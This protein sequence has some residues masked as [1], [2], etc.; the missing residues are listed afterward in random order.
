MYTSIIVLM[1]LALHWATAQPLGATGNGKSDLRS[2]GTQQM[3]C[4]DAERAAQIDKFSNLALR[5]YQLEADLNPEVRPTKIINQNKTTKQQQSKIE[6]AAQKESGSKIHQCDQVR[7]RGGP[8]FFEREAEQAHWAI[9]G[10]KI[11]W[12]KKWGELFKFFS[13]SC[14]DSKQISNRDGDP[15][16]G[17][18]DVR[19]ASGETVSGVEGRRSCHFADDPKNALRCRTRW[20]SK[21]SAQWN[22]SVGWVEVLTTGGVLVMLEV[23]SRSVGGIS[24]GVARAMVIRGVVLLMAICGMATPWYALAECMAATVIVMMEGQG[25]LVSTEE[26][27]M[28]F[29]HGIVLPVMMGGGLVLMALLTGGMVL[30][31][32]D[33]AKTWMS[34]FAGVYGRGVLRGWAIYVG[35][36]FA[37]QLVRCRS[38]VGALCAVVGTQ[39]E[40]AVAAGMELQATAA[41]AMLTGVLRGLANVAWRDPIAALVC[42]G[43]VAGGVLAGPWM[44]CGIATLAAN[45][46]WG[47]GALGTVVRMAGDMVMTGPDSGVL[48]ALASMKPP[49]GVQQK[50]GD[51]SRQEVTAERDTPALAGR[52][53]GRGATQRNRSG[54]TASGNRDV[55]SVD[56]GDAETGGTVATHAGEAGRT[57]EADGGNGDMEPGGSGGSGGND[58]TGG[59]DAAVGIAD[60]GG[61]EEVQWEDADVPPGVERRAEAREESEAMRGAYARLYA[62]ETIDDMQHRAGIT[63]T[64][65]WID[66]PAMKAWIASRV[67]LKLVADGPRAFAV[68]TGLVLEAAAKT[69]IRIVE[70]GKGNSMLGMCGAPEVRFTRVDNREQ[71]RRLRTL[72]ALGRGNLE[73]AR[74]TWSETVVEGIDADAEIRRLFPSG[75]GRRVEAMRELT[76]GGMSRVRRRLAGESEAEWDRVVLETIDGAEDNAPG[77]SGLRIGHLKQMLRG[78]GGALMKRAFGKMVDELLKGADGKHVRDVVVKLL[79]KGGG[80]ARPI[81]MGEVLPAVAK[82]LAAKVLRQDMQDCLLGM[83]Q[84]AEV[85]NGCQAAAREVDWMIGEGYGLLKL[86]MVNAFNAVE[87]DAIIEEVGKVSPDAAPFVAH[88]L[89]DGTYIT[90]CGRAVMMSRGV[91]QGDPLSMPIFAL[92]VARR[93]QAEMVDQQGARPLNGSGAD[94]R[95]GVRANGGTIVYG[96]YADDVVILARGLTDLRRGADAAKS[97]MERIGLE[98]NAAKS[99]IIPPRGS[100]T[101]EVAEM[102]GEWGAADM[103]KATMYLG[104]PVGEME[105]ARKLLE[106]KIGEVKSE[107]EG[108]A[109]IRSPLGQLMLM[110]ACHPLSRLQ[111]VLEGCA[112]GVVDEEAMER[113]NGMEEDAMRALLNFGQGATTVGWGRDLTEDGLRQMALPL[114]AGGLGISRAMDAGRLTEDGW[115]RYSDEERDE[116]LTERVKLMAQRGETDRVMAKRWR[117]QGRGLEWLDRTTL[118]RAVESALPGV[119]QTGTKKGTAEVQAGMLARMVGLCQIPRELRDEKCGAV[120]RPVSPEL[121]VDGTDHT[122]QCRVLAVNQRHEAAKRALK[123]LLMTAFEEKDIIFEARPSA[124]GAP[125]LRA[126]GPRGEGQKVPGDVVLMRQGEAPVYMDVSICYSTSRAYAESDRDEATRVW[127]DKVA[128]WNAEAQREP[129]RGAFIP[130]VMTTNGHLHPRS[131]NALIQLFPPGA[132]GDVIDGLRTMMLDVMLTTSELAALVVQKANQAIGRPADWAGDDVNGIME[133]AQPAQPQHGGVRRY[134]RQPAGRGRGSGRGQGRGGAGGR[135]SSRPAVAEVTAARP[136]A[137]AAGARAVARPAAAAVGARAVARPAAAAMEAVAGAAPLVGPAVRRPGQEEVGAAGM[138]RSKDVAALAAT[139]AEYSARR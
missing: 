42:A 91:V 7:N 85:Q 19:K 45:S 82:R 49:P 11:F 3:D 50:W 57:R 122:L 90:E 47:L 44:V 36:D 38:P 23:V 88:L 27:W 55:R 102:M 136:A 94:F 25:D 114:K 127:D 5:G 32:S 104:I 113:I 26:W 8:D 73:L 22:V 39:L 15:L 14:S 69:H 129:V 20:L 30:L 64:R 76:D 68:V 37:I 13:G 112:P 89:Q 35:G 117:E 120:H 116:R 75:N 81:G 93:L 4:R 83:G 100:R 137:A 108:W 53:S 61:S 139:M 6:F 62:P 118:R 77:R 106:Q 12:P 97:A 48:S 84:W 41:A 40:T 124:S 95:A 133:E 134:H 72:R 130:V 24:A 135:E 52:G 96:M 2:A 78:T 115:R 80:K 126:P 59:I 66:G 29:G 87:R 123:T 74:R 31:A 119:K 109:K 79:P 70:A 1:S 43:L 51:S 21:V 110:Q 56:T 34:W 65:K 58:E 46:W 28:A 92:T 33:G 111:F 60:H 67:P 138:T 17:P 71:T 132:S 54:G 98:F 10:Q 128:A 103:E 105:Y 16:W 101:E 121:L 131:R 9:F 107:T 125:I 86:D 99:C 63:A 18:E